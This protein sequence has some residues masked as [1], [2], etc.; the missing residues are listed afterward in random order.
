MN[1]VKKASPG[2]TLGGHVIPRWNT[3]PGMRWAFMFADIDS[4]EP[5]Y[6]SA[7]SILLLITLCF[8]A[9]L[10][11][12]FNSMQRKERGGLL[13]VFPAIIL[14]YWVLFQERLLS[15]DP[16]VHYYLGPAEVDVWLT[17]SLICLIFGAA[18]SLAIVLSAGIGRRF[19]GS[20]FLVLYILLIVSA[21]H[22]IGAML[23]RPPMTLQL[24]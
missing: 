2:L 19:Y 21:M 7:R 6:Y 10:V 22:K 8:L 17:N 13:L 16:Y 9:Y 4:G 1:N 23:S 5:S 18:F 12:P 14:A 11:S 20:L 24:S 15:L 3:T